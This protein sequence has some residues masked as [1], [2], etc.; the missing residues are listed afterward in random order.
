MTQFTETTVL[1]KFADGTSALRGYPVYEFFTD[2]DYATVV[3]ALYPGAE[4]RVLGTLEGTVNH[5]VVTEVDYDATGAKVAKRWRYLGQR[6]A[7]LP[8]ICDCG[9]GEYCPQFGVASR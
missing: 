4:A 1:I 6:P 5:T 2:D 8:T 7:P 9:K 3:A